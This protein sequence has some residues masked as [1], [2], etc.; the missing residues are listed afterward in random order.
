MIAHLPGGTVQQ[1]KSTGDA[2]PPPLSPTSPMLTKP[3][4]SIAEPK[5]LVFISLDTK[6]I[7]QYH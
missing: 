1:T 6:Q 3:W 7:I 4:F 2:L 5:I